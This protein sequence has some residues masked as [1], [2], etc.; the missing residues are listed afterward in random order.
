MHVNVVLVITELMTMVAEFGHK[1]NKIHT[2]IVHAK[3]YICEHPASLFMTRTKSANN[4]LLVNYSARRCR[5]WGHQS[6][7]RCEGVVVATI[8]FAFATTGVPV[9]AATDVA[10]SIDFIVISGATDVTIIDARGRCKIGGDQ[11][12]EGDKAGKIWASGI[13]YTFASS[14]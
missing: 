2:C 11:I 10:I 14:L 8:V 13:S 6:W 3:M 4:S 1:K 9:P 5:D 12:I 7:E